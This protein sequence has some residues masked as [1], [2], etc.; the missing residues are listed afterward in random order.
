MKKATREWVRKAEADYRL[1]QKAH[2]SAERFHDQVCFHC[3]QA[4]EKYLKALMEELGQAVPRIHDL[5]DLLASVLPYHTE[6]RSL[7][8]GLAFLTTFAVAARYPGI[9]TRKR[10]AS[11][12]LLWAHRC[13][14]LAAYFSA[15]GRGGNA[16]HNRSHLQ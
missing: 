13:A 12:G 11:S 7:R 14:R 9:R 4:A 3:Q 2:D 8:R 10:T 6:L 1:A 16:P 5:E 15:F